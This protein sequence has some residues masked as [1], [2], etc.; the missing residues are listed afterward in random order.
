MDSK[1]SS[2]ILDWRSIDPIDPSR[3]LTPLEHN[4]IVRRSIFQQFVLRFYQT[5]KGW[6]NA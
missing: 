1:S 3:Y 4:L 2:D 5:S 6:K